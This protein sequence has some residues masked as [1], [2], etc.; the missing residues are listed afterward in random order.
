MH[1]HVKD[2]ELDPSVGAIQEVAA[3]AAAPTT[4]LKVAAVLKSCD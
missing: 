1:L 3:S 2:S 4:P